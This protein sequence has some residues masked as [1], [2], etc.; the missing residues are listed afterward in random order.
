MNKIYIK[1]FW[2]KVKKTSK[3]WLWTAHTNGRYGQFW[4]NTKEKKYAHR[5]SYELNKGKIPKG[6]LV[7]HKCD[8]PICVNP[9]HLWLGTYKENMQDASAKGRTTTGEKSSTAKLKTADVLKIRKMYNTGR[10]TQK[11]IAKKFNVIQQNISLIILRKHWN[12][13]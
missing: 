7:C 4:I 3:C 2:E 11:E 12:T 6:L 10:F 5:I 9:K 13:V 8:N 1:N